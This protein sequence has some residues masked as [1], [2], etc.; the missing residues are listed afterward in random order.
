MTANQAP[1]P[2]LGQ[3]VGKRAS[4]RF[5][6]SESADKSNEITA[7]PALLELLDLS[8]IVTLDLRWGLKK[9]IAHQIHTAG[10]DYIL[11]LKSN[12]PRCFNRWNSGFSKCGRMASYPPH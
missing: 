5:S 10:A 3:C 1:K 2:A 12:H 11:S 8:C 6:A 9:S 7:I 4:A